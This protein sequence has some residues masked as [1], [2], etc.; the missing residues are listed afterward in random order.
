MLR[1]MDFH[2][3]FRSRHFHLVDTIYHWDQVWLRTKK[4]DFDQKK[5]CKPTFFE[6]IEILCFRFG[7]IRFD[8]SNGTIITDDTIWIRIP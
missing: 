8:L 6:R 7:G 3:L 5:N 1:P 2:P 4:V